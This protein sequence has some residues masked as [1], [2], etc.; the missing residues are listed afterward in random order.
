MKIYK[1]LDLDACGFIDF[2]VTTQNTF[3]KAKLVTKDIG[4]G[5]REIKDAFI[6]TTALHSSMFNIVK[7][8]YKDDIFDLSYNPVKEFTTDE[9]LFKLFK[10]AIDLEDYVLL[11]R[12]NITDYYPELIKIKL[13]YDEIP[14][15]FAKENYQFNIKKIIK[16]VANTVEDNDLL[17]FNDPV[18][19]NL[20][21]ILKELYEQSIDIKS[22]RIQLLKKDYNESDYSDRELHVFGKVC[23][24]TYDAIRSYKNYQ[25]R[26]LEIISE[27]LTLNV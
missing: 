3:I 15:C 22:A 1:C 5:N 4:D 21:N 20:I 18:Q 16:I 27:I 7:L 13:A 17:V 11:G 26:K 10:K 8:E 19:Y 24:L 12:G 14:F 25:N 9:D 23:S 6:S 2:D